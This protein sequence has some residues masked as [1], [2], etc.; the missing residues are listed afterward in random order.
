[1]DTAMNEYDF[2]NEELDNSPEDES[3]EPAKDSR[4]FV[5]KLEQEAKAGKAAKREAEEAQREAANAKR[6]L[7]FIK[8][9]IDI[10]SPTGKLF[11]KAYDGE[12]TIDAVKAAASEYGLIPTSQT[13]DVKNDLDALN[14][15]S[16]ASAGSTGVIAPTALD[17]IR[18]A[19]D[20]AAV[21]KVL[22]D[23]GIA[24][25]NEQPGGWVP[26]V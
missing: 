17:A 6:E 12:T 3:G 2:E 7:A 20:P 5:R 15:V 8:A 14:R 13:D 24:I 10:E 25:S 18:G 21:L 22:Q 4:Q 1:M 19:A 16:Q 26:L 11:A 9:G 23:N